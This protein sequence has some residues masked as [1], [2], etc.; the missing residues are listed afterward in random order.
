[1]REE[2]A[3]MDT[4]AFRKNRISILAGLTR[5][6][7]ICCDP[8]LFV[9]DY[10]GTSGKLE[11]VKDLI[12]AAK[13]NGRRVLLFSQFTSMLSIIEEELAQEGIETFYLRG[14][15]PPQERLSMVDAFNNGEKDV[16]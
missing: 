13:E 7:Q 3:Q 8:R 10:E 14:S 15:T 1:M 9:E 4:A 6:R 2:I 11:Q 5:L 12:Q 16:F